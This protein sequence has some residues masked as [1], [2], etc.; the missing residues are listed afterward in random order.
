MQQQWTSIAPK[1]N[2][3]AG[4]TN[5]KGNERR[6]APPPF[7]HVVAPTLIAFGVNDAVV[8]IA[9][10][11]NAAHRIPGAESAAVEE[12]HHLLSMSR[13]YEPAARRQLELVRG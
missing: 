10:A 2:R 11:T 13:N 8:P 9:H 6:L 7:S 3:Q 5:D 12:G 1:Q 4:W